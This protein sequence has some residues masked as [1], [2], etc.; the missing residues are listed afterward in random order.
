V[1]E[2]WQ[3]AEASRIGVL[4]LAVTESSLDDTTKRRIADALLEHEAALRQMIVD[5]RR[6]P[7][8]AGASLERVERF[9]TEREPA[10]EK[11]FTDE[12]YETV[13]R[14]HQVI[15]NQLSV[16]GSDP[17]EFVKLLTETLKPTAEQKA[18]IN[19]AI[20]RLADRIREL[21]AEWERLDNLPDRTGLEY[22]MI[23]WTEEIVA[24][25]LEAR[26][27]IRTALTADQRERFDT[28]F[29]FPLDPAEPTERSRADPHLRGSATRP[30]R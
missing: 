10:L 29:P 8:K 4:R 25:G 7:S 9:R 21:T 2:V 16:L 15:E 6:D 22:K 3:A 17:A 23:D 28:G 27:Q 5:A 30:G 13:G 18:K 1:T 24:L 14:R 11:L 19:P 26:S 20:D 12:Q